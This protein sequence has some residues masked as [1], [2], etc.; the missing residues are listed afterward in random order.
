MICCPPGKASGAMS[1]MREMM[2][3]LKLTVNEK[4][5]RECRVPD[6]AFTFLGFTFGRQ[7]SWNTGRAYTTLAQSKKKARGVCH[8]CLPLW[9]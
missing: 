2:G 6:E 1:V 9:A 5:T 3:Q 4:K 8:K 7:V